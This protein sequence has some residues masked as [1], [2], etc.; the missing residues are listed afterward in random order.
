[1]NTVLS[2]RVKFTLLI[3][4][5]LV[6]ALYFAAADPVR[7]SKKAAALKRID[8]ATHLTF[9]CG[10][11][12]SDI[13]LENIQQWALFK[14]TG[15]VELYRHQVEQSRQT[16]ASVR[17]TIAE[18][19]LK[20]FGQA[21]QGAIQ[22]VLD[23][24]KAL[25]AARDYF[26]QRKFGDDRDAPAA[27]DHRRIYVELS[28]HCSATVA[29]LVAET[30][31][32]SIRERLQNLVWFGQIS[33]ATEREIGLYLWAHQRGDL[34]P[35]AIVEVEHSGAL[36]RYLEKQILFASSPELRTYFESVFQHP[37][38]VAADTAALSFR[39]PEM[40]PPRSFLAAGEAD[41]E[42]KTV[43]WQAV[44]SPVEPTL[45]KELQDYT[46]SYL[47]TTSRERNANL[48]LLLGSIGVS[49]GFGIWLARDTC[50][51]ISAATVSIVTSAHTIAAT[52]ADAAQLGQQL[53][54]TTSEQS[55]YIEE[56]LSSLEEV[57]KTNHRNAEGATH[58]V[59]QIGESSRRAA[60]SA[61]SMR[62][63]L[64]CME[65]MNRTCEQTSAIIARINEIAF[66]TNLLAL[67]ASIEAA[68]AGEAGAGFAVVAQEVR[69]LAMRTTEASGETARLLESL[70]GTIG[71]GSSVAQ[72]VNGSFV[73]VQ[74]QTS[75]SVRLIN[76]I[77]GASQEVV[78]GLRTISDTTTK[79]NGGTRDTVEVADK[80]T[81][82]A[83]AMS[84]QAKALIGT[85]RQ[86]ENLV[87]G[88]A[89]FQ[90]TTPSSSRRDGR[91]GNVVTDDS[92]FAK[93]DQH[94]SARASTVE[95]TGEPIAGTNRKRVAR[96]SSRSRQNSKLVS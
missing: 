83:D 26:F 56:T 86:L 91:S 80:N 50:R 76:D 60:A 88:G 1:M 74:T 48:L 69:S 89:K 10:R 14:Q 59:E 78:E 73:E 95:S 42:K 58:A 16:M 45:L 53:A 35:H 30:T 92:A 40:K 11:L 54:G 8:Q 90:N 79:L 18:M 81:K 24:E 3:V 85:V 13:N 21:F 52:A 96:P 77:H 36:R 41:W 65:N 70:R 94:V 62:E 75:T 39:Q 55:N 12:K 7:L 38:Y 27:Q 34:P 93:G 32:T 20:N 43:A 82:I 68:R 46:A 87:T 28:K 67:N 72:T 19:D 5:P 49:A 61:E 44:I 64:T 66:Q 31:E 63:L 71:G 51:S 47:A 6:S 57:R 2:L 17:S 9:V 25:E 23:D 33:D 22:R 84:L 4:L 15:S 29:S 37:D